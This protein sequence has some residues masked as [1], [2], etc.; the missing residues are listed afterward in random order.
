MGTAC[1]LAIGSAAPCNKRIGKISIIST[2]YG[3]CQQCPCGFVK[4]ATKP[5]AANGEVC[6]LRLSAAASRAGRRLQRRPLDAEVSE[7]RAAAYRVEQVR[8]LPALG[9]ERLEHDQLRAH[10]AHPVGAPDP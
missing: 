1:G 2:F 3:S 9:V 4:R 7:V 8:Q 6:R 10:L 5:R